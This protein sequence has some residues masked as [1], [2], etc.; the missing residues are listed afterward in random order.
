MASAFVPTLSFHE[1]GKR[2]MR[3]WMPA[4][5]GMTSLF[6]GSGVGPGYS[7]RRD[8][9]HDFLPGRQARMNWRLKS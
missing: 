5:A 8:A 3:R 9:V 7:I 4:C 1:N 6:S 2:L